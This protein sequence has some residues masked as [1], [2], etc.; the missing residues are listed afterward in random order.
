MRQ[1]SLQSWAKR[2]SVFGLLVATGSTAFANQEGV[3]G[4]Q[5]EVPVAAEARNTTPVAGRTVRTGRLPAPIAIDSGKSAPVTTNAGSITLTPPPALTAAA[6]PLGTSFDGIGDTGEVPANPSI[7]IGPNHILQVVNGA[8]RV[9]DRIGVLSDVTNSLV[10][11]FGLP[12]GATG[13]TDPICHYDHFNDRFL[14]LM[15]ARN[16]AGT[17]GWYV[18]ATTKGRVPFAV[19]STWTVY[20]IRNDIDLPST[21]TDFAGDYA[22]IGF[23]DT[24]FY[25]TSNQHDSSGVFQYAKIRMYKKNDIYANRPVTPVE[26]NDVRDAVGNRVFTIQ[27]AITFGKPGRE[28]LVS[29]PPGAGSAVSVFTIDTTV[30]TRILQ[31]KLVNVNAWTAPQD[32][33]QKIPGP[34]VETGDARML[35]AV[36]RNNRIFMAHTVRR[37]TFPCAAHYIGINGANYGVVTDTTI[38]NP[39]FYY[40]NPAISVSAAGGLATV[41]NF[42]SINRFI[43]AAY[44][45]IN[46]SGG[47]LPL[48]ILREGQ[49]NYFVT[50]NGR[51][52]WGEHSGI[53]VDP[54]SPDR[55]WFNSMYATSIPFSWG[56]YV[57]STSLYG[58]RQANTAA[59]AGVAVRDQLFDWAKTTPVFGPLLP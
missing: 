55:I 29:C 48:A 35:N 50:V 31:K 32:A 49:G 24:Y 54:S 45:Q 41:L 5:P 18:L 9:T 2:L 34:L 22:R 21:N 27:P 33:F 46:S 12:A 38:G 14:V 26:F 15:T 4:P 37:G 17:D 30:Y 25:I 23:D 56:T 57:G 59:E 19:A 47:A 42:S 44:T 8:V 36:V 52:P 7:A 20:N 1:I 53:A 58:G 40:S 28:Y 51:V 13:L 39:S 16:A 11:T 43:G 10:S 3:V 6:P